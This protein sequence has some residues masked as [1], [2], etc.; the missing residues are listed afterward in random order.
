MNT[1]ERTPPNTARETLLKNTKR[2]QAARERLEK[3]ESKL[4]PII[5]LGNQGKIYHYYGRTRN[6]HF[7]LKPNDHKGKNIFAM[8]PI[9]ELEKWLSKTRK[10]RLPKS[11]LLD[12]VGDMLLE[13]TGGKV[14]NPEAMRGAGVWADGDALVYNAGEA[15]YKAT[16]KSTIAQTCNVTGKG[17]I[18]ERKGAL[19]APAATELT[20]AEAAAVMEVFSARPWK[21]P[22]AAEVLVGWTACAV[23]GAFLPMRPHIWIN[24]PAG[25][26]KT[27]TKNALCALMGGKVETNGKGG[28]ALVMGGAKTTEPALRRGLDKST[29]PVVMDEMEANGKKENRENIAANI[30]LARS[31][32]YGDDVGKVNM[33][34]SGTVENFPLR[35]AFCFLSI[36]NSLDG[37]AD[38]SRFLVLDITKLEAGE[39]LEAMRLRFADALRK[40]TADDYAA[41]LLARILNRAHAIRRDAAALHEYIGRTVNGRTAQLLAELMAGAWHLL[42]NT[43]MPDSYRQHAADIAT[44]VAQDL[45]ADSE[46]DRVINWLAD[47][48]PAGRNRTIRQTISAALSGDQKLAPQ[49]LEELE[50]SGVFLKDYDAKDA[51]RDG[52]PER[53]GKRYARI[54]LGNKELKQAFSMTMWGCGKNALGKALEQGHGVFC[55]HAKVGGT[56]TPCAFIPLEYIIGTPEE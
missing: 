8:A 41:H 14:Y 1:I 44:T 31:A 20:A 56:S 17:L 33:D 35:S 15:C 27:E 5:A 40:V 50:A 51:Q 16:S 11:K 25:T 21:Q 29:R 7:V 23:L 47:I 13:A 46:A 10:V 24:A 19:P 9:E 52:C 53:E 49:A 6:K 43:P 39:A 18:Y 30:E 45:A 42:H 12:V 4:P 28:L 38:L 48:R 54:H 37:D 3:E 32:S 55:K 26:G 22:Y 36:R 34:G 2:A